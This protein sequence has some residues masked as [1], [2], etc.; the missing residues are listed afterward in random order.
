MPVMWSRKSGCMLELF[1]PLSNPVS[2]TVTII[3]LP[4]NPDHDESMADMFV[5]VH[6]SSTFMTSIPLEFITSNTGR[7]SIHSIRS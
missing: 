7:P 3:P 1:T 6:V 4:F 2:A 5:V